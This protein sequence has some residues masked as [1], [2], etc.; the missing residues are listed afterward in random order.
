MCPASKYGSF[1]NCDCSGSVPGKGHRSALQSLGKYCCEYALQFRS[2]WK[3]EIPPPTVSAYEY[4]GTDDK[5]SL[6]GARDKK[7]ATPH[8]VLSRSQVVGT[9][10]C[11]P[12][13]WE[14]SYC[15]MSSRNLCLDFSEGF[16]CCQS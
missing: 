12:G 16:S 6:S 14:C 15:E 9:G 4:L 10:Q 11:P 7:R 13:V 8:G 2:P 5:T 3:D 1:D